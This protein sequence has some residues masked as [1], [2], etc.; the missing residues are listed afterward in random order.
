[1]RA[2]PDVWYIVDGW[3]TFEEGRLLQGL[4]AGRDVLEL[5]S[6]RGRSAIAM[7]ATARSVVTVD[8]HVGDVH[9]GA[10]DTWSDLLNNLER[11]GAAGN[12]AA[13]RMRLEDVNVGAMAGR[14]D[15]VFIDSE[16]TPAA[17]ERDTRIALSAVKPGGLIAYHDW[18]AD[19]AAGAASAGVQ[20]TLVAG[21]LA[22]YHVPTE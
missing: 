3:L 11:T 18:I 9:T 17:A 10:A 8:A 12:V 14:F 13:R 4:A 5:G 19:V 20:A 1:M 22:V 2:H 21:S 6:W 7:S 15:L 16:H